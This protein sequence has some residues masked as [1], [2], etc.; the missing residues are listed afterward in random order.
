M[1]KGVWEGTVR[2]R[3]GNGAKDENRIEVIVIVKASK[4]HD[5]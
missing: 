5:E 3:V 4:R 1:K 2:D